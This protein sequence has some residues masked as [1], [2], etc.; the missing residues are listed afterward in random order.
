MRPKTEVYLLS[1][2]SKVG[3]RPI[4]VSSQYHP[5]MRVSTP[6]LV[7]AR[8]ALGMLI[9]GGVLIISVDPWIPWTDE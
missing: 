1:E 8:L 6:S 5:L 2:H 4:Y 7:M 9:I 3:E